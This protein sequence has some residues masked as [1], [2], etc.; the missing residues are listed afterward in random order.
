MSVRNAAGVLQICVGAGGTYRS[1]SPEMSVIMQL[2]FGNT[3]SREFNSGSALSQ[4][5]DPVICKDV[6]W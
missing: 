4:L 3:L 1:D 5:D 6:L 2:W